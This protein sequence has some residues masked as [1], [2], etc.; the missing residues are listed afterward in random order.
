MRV[1]HQVLAPVIAQLHDVAPEGVIQGTGSEGV[2]VHPPHH[3][4]SFVDPGRLTLRTRPWAL[5]D[6]CGSPSP[7]ACDC[8]AS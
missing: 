1:D 5:D 2:W 4:G 3:I 8:S 6:A 7:R